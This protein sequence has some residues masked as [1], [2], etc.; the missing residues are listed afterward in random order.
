MLTNYY[1]LFDII[2]PASVFFASLN[3][4]FHATFIVFF[5]FRP[6]DSL[7]IYVSDIFLAKRLGDL[8]YPFV[9]FL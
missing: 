8:K 1:Y 5:N 4:Y 2:I 7:L 9:Y 3:Y 6:I